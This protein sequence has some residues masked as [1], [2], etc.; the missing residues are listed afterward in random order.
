MGIRTKALVIALV[1]LTNFT[2]VTNSNLGYSFAGPLEPNPN[3]TWIECR[4]FIIAHA[5]SYDQVTLD[6]FRSET[7]LGIV[8][9]SVLSTESSSR[10]KSPDLRGNGWPE[11]NMV[12]EFATESEVL[13]SANMIYMATTGSPMP[14][15]SGPRK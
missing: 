6:R 4:D 14:S 2:L 12:I 9:W 3:I 11:S 7:E 10:L 5:T 8:T 13:T 15:N 1:S